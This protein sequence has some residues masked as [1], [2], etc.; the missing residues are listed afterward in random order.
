MGRDHPDGPESPGKV[1][2]VVGEEADDEVRREVK[3]PSRQ[4]LSVLLKDGVGDPEGEEPRHGV[5]ALSRSPSPM[6]IE[7]V[8]LTP[9]K[10]RR[11]ASIV[12][13]SAAL[14][15]PIPIQRADERAAASVT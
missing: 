14:G 15:L 8:K 6:T 12:A 9:S 2:G 5:G 7:P 11:I 4:D 10:A 13:C 3:L 1:A